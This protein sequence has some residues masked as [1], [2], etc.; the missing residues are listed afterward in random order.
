MSKCH[1][2][3]YRIAEFAALAGVTVRAL[4]HY[5]RLGL[6]KPRRTAAGYRV[7]TDR[8]L[9]VL[10]Q[11]VVLK[12]IGVPLK[13]IPLVRIDAP[14]DL[15][16][17]FVRQ[18]LTLEARRRLLSSTI[19]AIAAAEESVRMTGRADATLFKRI[20]EVIE[21]QQ[22]HEHWRQ[23]ANELIGQK[24]V[25]LSAMS[26]EERE[27][28]RQRWVDLFADIRAALDEDPAGPCG[29]ALA[30]RYLELG[31][32]MADATNEK[33]TD[34]F[35]AKPASFDSDTLLEGLADEQRAKIKRALGPFSDP[36]ERD[37]IRRALAARGET[38]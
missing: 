33:L 14:A 11:I 38:R 15:V 31:R 36:R 32:Q 2:K 16:N 20:I 13:Q 10:E 30:A 9:H 29:H 28:L 3:T 22:N 25:R 19:E 21:M 8:D 6:L 35:M 18:R 17:A 7:Y 37:F 4:R 27:A 26:G 1:D 12:F 34:H 24:R 5:D 23:Q